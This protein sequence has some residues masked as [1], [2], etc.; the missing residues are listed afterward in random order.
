[1]AK[2]SGPFQPVGKVGDYQFYRAKYVDGVIVRHLPA[3]KSEQV[4]TEDAYTNTRAYAA[5]FGRCSDM[6]GALVRGL[7]TR[8]RYVLKPFRTSEMTKFLLGMQKMDTI[9]PIGRRTIFVPNWQDEIQNKLLSLSKNNANTFASVTGDGHVTFDERIPGL[10]V[11]SDLYFTIYSELPAMYNN[12]DGVLVYNSF[13][14]YKM[15][16]PNRESPLEKSVSAFV[17][18]KVSDNPPV[19]SVDIPRSSFGRNINAQY[20]QSRIVTI[21]FNPTNSFVQF[22]VVLLPY[23]QVGGQKYVQQKLCS[24]A[25]VPCEVG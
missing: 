23:V 19:Y 24:V 22:L 4:K 5:D 10:S 18:L 14:L 17:N 7:V 9:H 11:D 13:I 6:A 8:W 2:L 3:N 12:I 21:S 1:M 16:D 25:C 20:I 15:A